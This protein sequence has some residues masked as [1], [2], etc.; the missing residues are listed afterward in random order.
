MFDTNDTTEQMP[1]EAELTAAINGIA[2]DYYGLPVATIEQIAA[3]AQAEKREAFVIDSPGAADWLLG[4]IAAVRAKKDLIKAQTAQMLAQL[5]ADERSLLRFEPMLREWGAQELARRGGRRKSL[6]LFHGT[7]T[8]RKVP[9]GLKVAD[10]GAA[11]NEAVARGLIKLDAAGYRAAAIEARKATGEILPG[12]EVTP[13]S[14]H[15]GIKFGKAGP[16]DAE[17]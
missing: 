13:E 9:A 7:L 11:L 10:E 1:T 8:Y 4:K 2:A 12:I 14:E 15:F 5:D 6:P 3:D 16:E 17:E